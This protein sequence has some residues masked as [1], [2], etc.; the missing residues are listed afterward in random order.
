M[1]VTTTFFFFFYKQVV[2]C[3]AHRLPNFRFSPVCGYYWSCRKEDEFPLVSGYVTLLSG[4]EM[5]GLPIRHKKM[6]QFVAMLE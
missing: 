3:S 4:I 1:R 2:R 6:G 5:S